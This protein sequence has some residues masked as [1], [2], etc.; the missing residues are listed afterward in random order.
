M[1]SELPKLKSEVRE[2]QIWESCE[3]YGEMGGARPLFQAGGR[4]KWAAPV[5]YA[6]FMCWFFDG[7]RSVREDVRRSG[8]ITLKGRDSSVSLAPLWLN[9][10][11]EK[12]VLPRNTA[13]GVPV[14]FTLVD[15]PFNPHLILDPKYQCALKRPFTVRVVLFGHY[16]DVME[17]E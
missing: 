2:V 13:G 11:S 6:K 3:W 12:Y 17:L 7:Q 9:V 1:N 16:A 8:I 14:D 5:F 10:E 4:S 15:R